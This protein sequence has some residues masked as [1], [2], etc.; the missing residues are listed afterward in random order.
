MS[1]RLA[2]CFFWRRGQGYK[3]KSEWEGALRGIKT[4]ETHWLLYNSWRDIL[5]RL[6]FEVSEGA[7]LF[8]LLAVYDSAGPNNESVVE[9]CSV[10]KRMTEVR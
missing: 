8:Y 2:G 3:N 6:V 7:L 10:E 4:L 1:Y 5:V 9:A